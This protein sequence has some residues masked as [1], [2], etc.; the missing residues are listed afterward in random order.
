[1]PT[2]IKSEYVISK[3]DC[4]SEVSLI[5]MQLAP[6]DDIIDL[7][8]DVPNRKLWVTQ[9]AASDLA[10]VQPIVLPLT[11]ALD[12]LNLGSQWQ[13]SDIVTPTEA[14]GGITT[15][16]V[17]DTQAT[18]QQQRTLL[19]WVLAINAGFFVLE[20][21]VGWFANSIGVIADSLDMLAD[22]LVYG[23]SLFVVGAA[24]IQ[25]KRVARYAGWLQLLLAGVGFFEVIRRFINHETLPDPWL[26]IGVS[27]LALIGNA[28][29]LYLLQKTAK[30]TQ[31]PDAAPSNMTTNDAAPA[32]LTASM[33]FTSND[34]IV[35]LGVIVAA[36][37]VWWLGSPLP[38][39]LIGG[40]V[41]ILVLRGAIRILALGK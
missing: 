8:F 3:M 24:A 12:E 14:S 22:S 27:L 28:T 33:I 37:L 17:S 1:M 20:L 23:M 6:L 5:R 19:W 29:C 11:Q 41:F 30:P 26:M 10:D 4:P 34:I 21:L 13:H 25:Q 39:L 35:N 9:Q 2:V 15:T 36:L 31:A 32:H 40:L 38:D 18:Q 7:A 16:N